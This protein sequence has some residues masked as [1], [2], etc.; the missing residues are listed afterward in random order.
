[1]ECSKR[2]KTTG[3]AVMSVFIVWHVVGIGIVGPSRESYIHDRLMNYFEHY[4]SLFHLNRSW[5]FYAPDPYPGS[6]LSYETVDSS[7]ERKT[8]PLTQAR[9]KFD[10]A[11]FRY[12]NF[13]AYL[14]SDP[15]YTKDRGY[16]I[17]LAHYLCSRHSGSY[18]ASINFVLLNQKPFTHKDYRQGKHPLEEEFLQKSVFGPYPC[19]KIE[20][21]L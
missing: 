18:V 7:G 11:Y 1:M 2:G 13:Y 8:Y 4:L 16:D 12:T 20:R 5:P 19:N 3:Y 14:F 15:Q 21:H 10:H 6:V 17:S 9:P